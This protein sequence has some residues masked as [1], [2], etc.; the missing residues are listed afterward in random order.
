[1]LPSSRI[2]IL[3]LLALAA[4]LSAAEK[5]AIKKP[6]VVWDGDGANVGSGWAKAGGDK[7]ATFESGPGDAASKNVARLH[8]EGEHWV[9]AGWRWVK[10]DSKTGFNAKP[11]AAF[12]FVMKGDKVQTMPEDVK[13]I[14]VSTGADGSRVEGPEASLAA[15]APKA[16]GGG[17]AWIEVVVPVKVLIA[18]KDFDATN[19][20]EVMFIATGGKAINA[21]LLFDNLGFAKAK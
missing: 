8:A 17:K 1:M 6:T 4:A 16:L 18:A 7:P 20:T 14:L 3:P 9:R 19:V 12:C 21:D 15:L 2:V 5:A 11:F 13:I 10:P